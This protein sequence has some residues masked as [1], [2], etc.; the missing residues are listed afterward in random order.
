MS[1]LL[2]FNFKNSVRI[3]LYNRSNFALRLLNKWYWVT[4]L[5]TCKRMESD[6]YFIPYAKMQKSALT[7]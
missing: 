3:L 1:Q 5:A 4:E 7:T 6:P 2:V